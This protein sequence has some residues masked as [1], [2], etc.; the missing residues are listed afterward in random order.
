MIDHVSSYTTQYER[1]KR[2]YECAFAPLGYHKQTEFVA[3]WNQDFPE[4]R[5][6]A[7]GPDK[8][9]VFWLIETT[10]SHSLRHIAFTAHTRADVEGFYA[11]AIEASGTDNG[12]PGLRPVYHPDYF[13]AF[14]FDPDGNNVEAVC[15]SAG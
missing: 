7:F 6:C 3:E 8:K 9:S 14:V 13:A 12:K 5:M 4:Q 1:A 2:F 10:V 15:H 11:N